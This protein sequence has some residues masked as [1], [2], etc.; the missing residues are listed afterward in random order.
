LLPKSEL[1]PGVYLVG[2]LTR[3]VRGGCVTSI[4]TTTETD[5]TVELPCVDLEDLDSSER[6]LILT[7]TAVAGSYCR[8]SRLCNQLR[9]EHLNSEERASLVAIY[10]E[11]NI[12]YLPGDKSK[13]TS[14]IEH[15]I[16]TPTVDTHRAISVKPYGISEAQNDEVQRQTGQMIADGIM[17]HSTS[18]WNSPILVFPKKPDASDKKKWRVVVDFHKLKEFYYFWCVELAGKFKI[19]F[20]Y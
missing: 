18:P 6:A 1:L 5:L 10:E 11:Y 8:L 14:S 3:V 17:Q 19:F 7:F 4:I 20:S 2:S 13:C 15:A 9:L 12:F 16:P